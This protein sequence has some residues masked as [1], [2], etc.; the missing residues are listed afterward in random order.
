[1]TIVKQNPKNFGFLFD[2]FPVNWGKDASSENY[3]PAVNV[4]ET[5]EGYHVEIVAPGRKKEDFSVQVTD[6]ILTIGYEKKEQTEASDFKTI[7]REFTFNSFKR[8]FTL[9]EKVNANGIQAKYDNGVLKLLIPK[10][11]EVKLAPKSIEIS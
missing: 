11:E 10:K 6:N 9:N 8:S 3:L 4:H 7:R 1:M 5:T 2:G